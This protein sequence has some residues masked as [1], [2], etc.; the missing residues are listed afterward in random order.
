VADYYGNYTGG[1]GASNISIHLVVNEGTK[2]T[3][4]VDVNFALY[5]ERTVGTGFFAGTN[6]GNTASVNINGSVFNY[7]NYTYDFRTG[8]GTFRQFFIGSGTQR[9]TTSSPLSIGVSA[10]TNQGVNPPGTA[11][12]SGSFTVTPNNVPAPV[13]STNERLTGAVVGSSYSSSV[14]ASNTLNYSVFGTMIP[15]LTLNT[16]GTITGT[17]TVVG[18]Q[19]FTARANGEDFS[20]DKLFR[21]LVVGG[22][23]LW[24]GTAFVYSKAKIWN[25]TTFVEKIPKI[26]NGSAWV[27]TQ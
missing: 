24:N 1:S 23:Q 15:G 11:S 14:S 22:T 9:V 2:T 25:G 20:T 27:G 16:N 13:F 4:Y 5:I 12:T 18:D 8:S 3:T 6:S 21:I 17:P 19:S 26:W 7:S 10:N